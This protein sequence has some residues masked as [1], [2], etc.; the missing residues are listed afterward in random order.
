ML[1]L[2]P[3]WSN[4]KVCHWLATVVVAVISA[5]PVLFGH[6]TLS[7]NFMRRFNPTLGDHTLTV[8]IGFDKSNGS[9]KVIFEPPQVCPDP[10]TNCATLVEVLPFE[11][12]LAMTEISPPS[13]ELNV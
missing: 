3:E 9:S 13:K 7:S 4:V 1:S 10:F 6:G 5:E 12:G 2:I 8:T 11:S